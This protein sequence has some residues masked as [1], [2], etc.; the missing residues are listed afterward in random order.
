MKGK[1]SRI[2]SIVA[3]ST[4]STVLLVLVLI[5]KSDT[6]AKK[7]RL[8]QIQ[9]EYSN[10]QRKIE[11]E[12]VSMPRNTE[13]DWGKIREVERN[14]KEMPMPP[15]A[16]QLIRELSQPSSAQPKIDL[17]TRI[18]YSRDSLGTESFFMQ[19]LQKMK[20]ILSL[21]KNTRNL[22]KSW[23]ERIYA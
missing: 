23:N 16:D 5:T 18:F 3:V 17:E 9:T 8:Q 2:L 19:V 12:I 22:L 10:K 21:K 11:A 15:E 14:L 7:E 4:V 13:E 20:K 1:F 6:S